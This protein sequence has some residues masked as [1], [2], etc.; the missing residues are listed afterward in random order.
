MAIATWTVYNRQLD[1]FAVSRVLVFAALLHAFCHV[2]TCASST[3]DRAVKNGRVKCVEALLVP[4]GM[5][6][7]G[8]VEVKAW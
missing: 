7:L 4:L 5:R 6:A 2:V 8:A 1:A 3:T